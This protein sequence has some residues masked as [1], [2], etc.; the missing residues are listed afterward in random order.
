MSLKVK[1]SNKLIDLLWKTKIR[2]K[3]AKGGRG[4]AK[5]IGF[6]IY[7]IEYALKNPGA[8]IMCVRGTQI[9][10]SDSSLQILKDVIDMLG[11]SEAFEL[12]EH[13]LKS[14]EGTEFLFYGA[15]NPGGFKSVQGVDLLWIDEATEL[16]KSAWEYLVPTI[17]KEDSEILVSFNPEDEND[18]VYDMFITNK[19]DNAKVVTVNYWDNP[20]FP[21]VLRQEMEYDKKTNYKKYLHV[22]CGELRQAIEGALWH[23]NIIRYGEPLNECERVVVA[24][25]PSGS[26]NKYA[27]EAGIVIVGKIKQQ[28]FLLGDCSEKLSPLKQAQRAIDAYKKFDADCIVLEKNGVGAGMKTIIHQIDRTIRVKE[29]V[30]TKG[31][32]L[33]AEPIVSLYEQGLISHVKKFANLEYEMLTYTGDTREQ[34]PNRLDAMVYGFTELFKNGIIKNKNFTIG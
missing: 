25:D 10:I 16:S 12:T 33:R 23:E 28:G 24:L 7:V 29:V 19:H 21:E 30:A 1:I 17:R 27:D 18:T 15:K 34:S 14:K 6:G 32:I 9:R 4:G 20:Y 13:T 8:K 5:S 22:W 11:Y 31:K 26:D 3:V 2:Y